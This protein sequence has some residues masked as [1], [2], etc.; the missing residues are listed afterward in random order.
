MNN[1]YLGLSSYTEELLK[2]GYQFNGREIASANLASLIYDNLFVTL[3]G[4]SGIGKTSLLQA[5][6]FPLLRRKGFI[7]VYL[8]LTE[9]KDPKLESENNNN[10]QTQDTE[11]QNKE[12]NP[13]HDKVKEAKQ[14]DSNNEE[15][16]EP[17]ASVLWK[18]LCEE[19]KE[20]EVQYE[21]WD[22]SDKY[23]PNNE[24]DEKHNSDFTDPLV[25]RKLFAAGRFVD[26]EGKEV[27]PI[28]VLDQFEEVLYKAPKASELLLSQLYALVNDN[29]N[30]KIPHPTWHTDNDFRIVVSIREDDLFLLEDVIDKLNCI[31]LKSNRYRLLPLSE[32]E[33]R[34]V[35]LNPLYGKNIVKKEEENALVEG[36]L[37]QS[38][39]SGETV[40]TL[41]LSLT[42]FVLFENSVAKWKPI[43]DEINKFKDNIETYYKEA[44]KELPEKQRFY[45]EDHLVDEEGRRTS[46]YSNDFE[47]NVPKAKELKL[48]ENSNN[49][50]I[51]NKNQ[52]RIELIHDQLAKTVSNLRKNRKSKKVRIYGIITLIIGLLTLL[53]YSLTVIP[54]NK[55]RI[56]TSNEKIRL[57]NNVYVEEYHIDSSG[58]KPDDSFN[59]YDCPNLKIIKINNRHAKINIFKCFNLSNIQIP[60][61]FEGEINVY[62]CPSLSHL[63]DSINFR[64]SGNKDLFKTDFNTFL[65][66]SGIQDTIFCQDFFCLKDI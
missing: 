16:A 53:F 26:K 17:A 8:R 49:H 6:V 36:I 63:A 39:G 46:I 43:L 27:I 31:E 9:V 2:E 42:C 19:L 10:Q 51:L 30:L 54:Q 38:K 66:G 25:L 50:R 13:K 12:N 33:V 60:P 56:L 29:Y 18:L 35:I 44:T 7:P 11:E 5:G 21:Y 4:R 3:Y 45:L 58:L 65:L 15:S 52:D 59:I 57:A 37:K 55:S 23:V 64:S 41:M 40:N 28:I 22:D 61:F 47:E 48:A 20:N 14:K 24:P 62:D 32:S 1:P 34:D